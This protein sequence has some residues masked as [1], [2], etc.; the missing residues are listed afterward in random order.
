MK[1]LLILLLLTANFSSFASRLLIVP[2]CIE[3]SKG[4]YSLTMEK[5][6]PWIYIRECD[7]V[8]M[9]MRVEHYKNGILDGHW[10][11]W[12]GTGKA[13]QGNY[14]NGN[15]DGEWIY[16]NKKE[17]YKNGVLLKM[18]KYHGLD[19]EDKWFEE[20]YKD[21]KKDGQKNIWNRYG[22]IMLA[23]NF[24]DGKED[25]KWTWYKNGQI[26]AEAIYKDGVCISGDCPD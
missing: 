21:D 20:N 23:A 16:S 24:K 22:Q 10:I 14:V 15:R 12:D 9:M 1:K 7:N 11:K 18:T 17:V 26:E 2:E 4:D 3:D 8:T 13:A 6:G 25:G 5:E 19:Y